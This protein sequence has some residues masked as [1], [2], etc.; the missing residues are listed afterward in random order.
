M[1]ES[2]LQNLKEF[3]RTP[4]G[5]TWYKVNLHV[6]A[7]GQDPDKIVD[8]A[9][10]ANISLIAI[11]DHN[12]F[13]FVKPVQDAAA[14]RPD[15][16]LIVLPGIEITLEEGAH[17]LA[18]F[19]R[20]FSETS[21]TLFLGTLKLPTDGTDRNAVR[22]RTCS[23]VLTDISDTKGITVVPHPYSDDIGFL[24]KARKISTKMD[25]LESG[26]IGLIQIANEKV[27]FVD[28]D[29]N[30]KWQ[31][32]YVLSTTSPS[33]ISA[34]DYCLAP[35]APSEAKRPEEIERGAVWLKLGSR[36]IRG[37]RQVTCEPRTCISNNPPTDVKVFKLLGM[38][39]EGGFFNGLKIGFSPDMT[40][41]IGENHSGKTAIF[42]FISFALG[43]DQ[44]VL[45]LPDRKEELDLLLRR[46]NAILQSSSMVNLYLCRNG[47]VY[48]VSRVFNPEFDKKSSDVVR[49]QTNPQVLKFD[50]AKDELLPVDLSE[51]PV[52]P[53]IYTQGHVGV[54][55]KSVKSQL[56]LIDDLAGLAGYRMR[57]EELKKQLKENADAIAGLQEETEKLAGTV[58]SLT[59]LKQELEE[60]EKHLEATDNNKWQTSASVIKGIRNRI[61][62]LEKSLGSKEKDAF[63][64]Q[65]KVDVPKFDA[66]Q[67]ALP[68]LIKSLS[69]AGN[70]Y[71]SLI[72]AVV[73]QLDAAI[74][75]AKETCTPLFAK[76]DEQFDIH[77]K[78]V[79]TALRKRGFD[80]PEQ[81][82]IKVEDLRGQITT[83]ET[84]DAPLLAAIEQSIAD[85]G[86]NR[87]ELLEHFKTTSEIIARSRESKIEGLNKNIA[88][89]IVISLE[90]PDIQRYIDLLKEV[91]GEIA[92]K[93]RKIQK[94]DEQLALIAYNLQPH[95]LVDAILN[96][97]SLKKKEGEVATLV[98]LCGITQNTQDVL[99]SLKDN[100]R[101]LHKLQVFEAEP[102]P[103]I[104]LRREGTDKFADLRT[105]VS[106]GE[107]S[108]T[109]LALALMARDVPLIIDQPEDELGYNYIVNKIVPKI[110]KAKGERQVLL[111]SHNANIPVL[112]DAE[113][114]LKVRN[115][116]VE[117]QSRCTI[118]Q[119]GTFAEESMCSKLLELEG[120]E[121]A[122]QVRQYR[123]AIPRRPGIY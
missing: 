85:W 114:I 36:T 115:D 49:I 63:R 84:K 24:D 87:T 29:E 17:I 113:F 37:L 83:I 53:E 117:S 123:Y 105:E 120:G 118:E 73:T 61:D 39:V 33:V 57:A 1:A 44:S 121:R 103:K 40:C 4:P 6:H 94:R 45:A 109:I 55:R 77:K 21:Q 43:R 56:S 2:K 106:P 64:T 10:K 76:W 98:E 35:I 72:D 52:F 20:D 18:I 69:A 82:L 70:A 50:P 59:R 25:W 89:D 5:A 79:A 8:A 122:F 111:I 41:I 7:A 31:N 51:I 16:D 32:R 81:L 26:N 116:P 3:L 101:S 108:S 19:D 104:V 13:R 71:N 11:T 110:L 97:G 88:P 107:Q 67:V 62:F 30:G 96:G 80:S 15:T 65:W 38:T 12:S 68:E 14:K 60:H 74:T 27:K 93:D 95:Q 42:D 28:F 78:L 9:I 48:C 22:D 34:S 58:G 46:L 100:V 112:A 66:T 47:A 99:C 86:K 92:S 54:L 23:Q 90:K 119:A 91:C 102:I 75:Q